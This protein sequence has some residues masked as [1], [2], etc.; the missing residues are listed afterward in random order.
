MLKL[1]NKIIC[2]CLCVSA[3]CFDL[4][5]RRKDAERL[6]G[7]FYQCGGIDSESA[8]YKVKEYLSDGEISAKDAAIETT[9][10]TGIGA[11][12]GAATAFT[13]TTVATAFP[14]IAIALTTISPALLA[15]G[16]VG[17]IQQFF[18]ILEEHKQEVKAYYDSMT[19]QELQYLRQAEAE[20]IYEHEKTLSILEQ[21]QKITEEYLNLRFCWVT[22]NKF[23][24]CQL[25]RD[26][27][28][29]RRTRQG[30][31]L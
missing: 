29:S 15:V 1:I 12:I 23:V 13:V 7:V 9:K 20:L 5:Q 14:P 21:Q 27:Q 3:D 11:G 6:I 25:L 24:C 31:Q 18:K 22:A 10:E 28:N 4:T 8:A 2:V 16:G 26:L 19:E 30:F 17:M